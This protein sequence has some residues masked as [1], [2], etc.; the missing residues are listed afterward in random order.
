MAEV[1]SAVLSSYDRVLESLRPV[2]G[3]ASLH[4]PGAQLLCEPSPA[5]AHLASGDWSNAYGILAPPA[6]EAAVRWSAAG[7]ALLS[8][9]AYAEVRRYRS[10]AR[11]LTDYDAA[12]C[13]ESSEA[14]AGIP[15]R[16]MLMTPSSCREERHPWHEEMREASREVRAAAAR[17]VLTA[18]RSFRDRLEAS[19]AGVLVAMGPRESCSPMDSY[20]AWA[21][22]RLAAARR[23]RSDSL[24][25]V[26]RPDSRS[27][28]RLRLSCRQLQDWPPGLSVDTDRRSM[29]LDGCLFSAET[30]READT[31]ADWPVL[32]SRVPDVQERFL[33]EEGSVAGLRSID[34]W[35]GQVALW[36]SGKPR[37]FGIRPPAVLRPASLADSLWL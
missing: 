8:E 2:A 22:G 36:H 37:R 30:C 11:L 28:R 5:F 6:V 34:D 20:Q 7:S 29:T 14:M 32:A 13:D 21:D 10:Y 27:R 19:A 35:V 26:A 23:V 31:A 18:L 17:A 4:H 3:G 12:G 9:G 25:W 15:L 1:I 16:S 24:A 33:S